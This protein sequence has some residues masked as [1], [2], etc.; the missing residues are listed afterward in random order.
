MAVPF[1]VNGS[2]NHY[3]IGTFWMGKMKKNQKKDTIPDDITIIW[4]NVV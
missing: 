3:V 1:M 2:T 4:V